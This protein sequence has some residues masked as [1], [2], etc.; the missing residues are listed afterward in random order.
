MADVTTRSPVHRNKVLSE[1][2][3]RLSCPSFTA[4]TVADKAI[5]LHQGDPCEH[6]FYIS[7][8]RVKLSRMNHRGDQFTIAVLTEGQLFG[9]ALSNQSNEPHPNTAEAKGRA[10][11]HRVQ[12][13]EFKRLLAHQPLLA[14]EVLGIQS[15]WQRAL[16]RKLELLMF[17]DVRSR[18][19]ET[20]RALAGS[21]GGHCAHGFELD[22]KLT[23]QEL[24]DL[25]GATRPV[26]S[27]ILNEFKERRILDY[28]RTLICIQD[29]DALE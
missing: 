16:E 18:L 3:W 9:A 12:L 17:H 19:V 25:V 28:H 27:T 7:K 23:Q 1:E 4:L 2:G 8:G 6:V 20:L 21:H 10:V 26:V 24:A 15:K 5:I 22:I 29:L 14:W 11:L 13:E